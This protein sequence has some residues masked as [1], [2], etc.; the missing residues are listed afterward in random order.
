MYRL[1]PSPSAP[2]LASPFVRLRVL[3]LNVWALPAGLAPH[4]D[5]RIRAIGE[6]L[7]E[8]AADVVGFQEAWTE[9]ARK[10]LLA[11]GKRAGYPHAW[12][13][14]D[15]FGG[16]GLL[17]LSRFP[18]AERRFIGFRVEGRAERFD[19]SDYYGG[20][21]FALL[22][23][24]TPGGPVAFVDTHLHAR[25]SRNLAT[26]AYLETRVAQAVQMAVALESVAEPLVAVGDFNLREGEPEYEVLVGLTGWIDAAAAL[27]R[28]QPTIDLENAYRESDSHA[29]G[30]RIDYIF[31]RDGAR[32]A[33][34][35]TAV[36]RVLDGALE[37]AG[38]P[39]SYSDHAAVW[40]ELEVGGRPS[41]RPAVTPQALATARDLLER[42]LDDARQR[43]RGE[44]AVA[45][46][47]V[48]WAA[49]SEIAA[50]RV[51][52]RALL[53]S[54][55]VVGL[56]VAA[57]FGWLASEPSA[58]RIAGFENALADL[59]RMDAARRRRGEAAEA[60]FRRPEPPVESKVE[61]RPRAKSS[62]AA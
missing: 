54:L 6:Q 21:G 49:G 62:R 52:R 61:S 51:R 55:G 12:L 42:G 27:D 38:G 9:S 46:G 44:I 57:G 59:D 14:P 47:A 35:P 8:L 33:I 58:A 18:I 13:R 26:D 10:A 53:R 29:L 5:E 40:A 56:V 31:S 19:H 48:A 36:R 17:V 20:K 7:P 28:R 15:A 45:A 2:V 34:A 4:E 23:L 25:Y 24:D 37:I 22:R 43:R 41:P 3:T 30:H 39:G 50:R 11:A 60:G 1:G 32:R 16:S